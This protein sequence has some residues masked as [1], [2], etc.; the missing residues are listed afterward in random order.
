MGETNENRLQG[1]Y[2][3]FS[4]PSVKQP[5]LQIYRLRVILGRKIQ[6]RRKKYFR[7]TPWACTGL[8][9]SIFLTIS[10]ILAFGVV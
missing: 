10:P 3:P 9:I 5:H 2:A 8:V 4:L 1:D 6:I 7:T